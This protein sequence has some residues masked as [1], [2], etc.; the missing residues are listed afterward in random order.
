VALFQ[1][2]GA[3]FENPPSV[4][5]VAAHWTEVTDLSAVQPAGFKLG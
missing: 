4:D 1:N 5:E 2:D 3:K